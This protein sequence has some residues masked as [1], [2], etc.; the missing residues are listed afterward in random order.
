MEQQQRN[1]NRFSSTDEKRRQS[2]V[3]FESL[4]EALF[5]KI[6]YVSNPFS[7][8]SSAVTSTSAYDGVSRIT[9]TAD[10]RFFRMDRESRMKCTFYLTQYSK[11]DGYLLSPVIYDSYSSLNTLSSTSSLRAYVGLRFKNSKIYTVTKEAGG[12]EVLE[13]IDMDIAGTG[14]TDTMLLEIKHNVTSTEIHLNSKL[15]R[16]VP[17]DLVGTY[18][19]QKTYL[20]FLALIK[21]TDGTGVNITAENIQ[22]IQTKT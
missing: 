22:F 5:E 10:G 20:P 8:A 11:L 21:S 1:L 3:T 15:I 4:G 9:D 12:T 2:D 19:T 13:E 17:S 6:N 16:T 14:Y 18:S 7:Q